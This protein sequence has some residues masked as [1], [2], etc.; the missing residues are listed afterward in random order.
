M[1]IHRLNETSLLAAAT[2]IAV[3]AS[4]IMVPRAAMADGAIAVGFPADVVKSGFSYGYHVN[5]KTR[6]DAR[7]GA[8]D[9]CRDNKV[10]PESARTLCTL[11]GSFKDEC[12]AIAMDPKA[13]T[14][15]VGFAIAADK[16]TAEERA[17]AFCTATAGKDRKGFCKID[18]SACDGK[19][20]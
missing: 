14:P 15:G 5:A 19:R 12:V 17:L 18:A 6:G 4:A 1:K 8:F 3:L 9:S 7:N 2:V 10:A 11:V 13:G 20:D 16:E